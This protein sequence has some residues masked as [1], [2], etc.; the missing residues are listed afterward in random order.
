MSIVSKV[1]SMDTGLNRGPND[2]ME[3]WVQRFPTSG[4]A[5]ILTGQSVHVD[6]IPALIE[7]LQAL[8]DEHTSSNPSA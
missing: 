7:M 3:A 8:H 4:D 5:L 1:H 6:R 2:V